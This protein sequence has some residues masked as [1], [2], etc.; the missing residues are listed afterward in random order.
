M[1]HIY[2]IL[3]TCIALATLNTSCNESH[4]LEEIPLD[5]Y[6][7]ENSYVTYDDFQMA[8]TDLYAKVR[9]IYS[10]D[11]G[12]NND[13]Y[14]VGTDIAYNARRDGNNRVGDYNN[15]VTPQA[16]LPTTT[17]RKWFKIITN[18][19]VI[20][21]RLADTK[22]SENEQNLIKAE[23]QLFR[24]WAY[25][26]LVYLYGGVPLITEEIT[27]P[28]TDFV[29]ASKEA[30]IDQIIEDATNAA[31]F[32][33]E[34]K[35]VIDGK[36]SK[37]VA[38]HLLAENYIT[39]GEYDKSIAAASKVIEESG[40][41]LMRQRF[42]SL[43]NEPGDVFY[44]LFRVDN[45]NR[46]Q[47]NTESIWVVQYELDV[48]GG[49]LTS[50]GAS[51]NQ[52][53]RNVS[54]AVFSMTTPDR[55]P[56]IYKNASASTL[57]IGGRGVSFVRP[58]NYFLY[59]I[60]GLDPAQD[61]RIV[62]NPD[63]RTSS[64]NIVRDFIYTDP[65]SSYFGKSIIDFPSPNNVGS[66]DWRW[67]PF[68]SKVTTPGQHPIGLIDDIEHMTLK[69]TAGATC[70]DMYIIRLAETYLL[71]AEAYLRKGDKDSAA[72]DINEVR[73][74]SNAIPVNASE[75]DLDYILDERARELTFE[76]FRRL[77]L[78]RMGVLVERVRKYNPLNK[79]N[80][81]DH[82]NLF[83]I[84]YSEIEANKSAILE[85]NPGYK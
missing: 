69:S 7:P 28:K 68:P 51:V 40:L 53:E 63:I 8:L 37:P 20:I 46:S 66:T 34:I 54:P 18:S 56:A 17:Y 19:N 65:S 44:D 2:I 61:N 84:P 79:N 43:Q 47:G 83:P 5:F 14:F 32:L 80:I 74:R 78:S 15:M 59:D 58:T 1:K 48:P 23:A 49:L 21:S 30:V 29:R 45:Q 76:E 38:Y 75:V 3:V 55:K 73:T 57:N 72:K 52:L 36:L 4:F 64:F 26:N 27:V 35:D 31:T 70:R 82:N 33:P 41:A 39:L 11:G 50:A 12:A 10:L 77:T 67:Y 22:L 42:G 60:W 6:S 85:Q 13:A 16:T 25:H 24:A 81:N 62:T 9:N 71:R